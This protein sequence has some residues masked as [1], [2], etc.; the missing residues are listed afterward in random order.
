MIVVFSLSALWWIWLRG[1]WKLPNGRNWGGKGLVLLG[2][3]IISKSLI[4][5]SVDDWGCVP[6]LLSTIVEVMKIMETSLIRSHAYTAKLSAPHPAAGHLW[7]TPLPDTPG[8][9]QAGLSQPLVGSLLPSPG[10]W[11]TRFCLCPLRVYFPLLCK[12]WQ[13]Y[14]GVNE[15][16]FQEDLCHTQVCCTQSPCPCSSP[17]LTHT[18]TGDTQTQFC[19]S[20]CGV[21]G[22]WCAQGLFE[23]SESLWWVWGLILNAILSLLPCFWGFYFALGHRVP[24]HSCSSAVQPLLQHRTAAVPTRYL[25]KWVLKCICSDLHANVQNS[26]IHN[27]QNLEEN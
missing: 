23:P 12:F 7:P 6:S 14:G 21:S 27:F 24:L 8:H 9:S 1:L 22:S 4:Q 11:C 13:L 10:S 17:L 18:S 19:F 25:F 3:A 2:G 15:E 16:L 26:L 20:L 5:F